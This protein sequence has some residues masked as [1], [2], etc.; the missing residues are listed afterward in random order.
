MIPNPATAPA[1]RR[2]YERRLAG[3]SWASL[4]KML[5]RELPREDGALWRPSTVGDLV[6][7]PL[8]IGRLERT[9]GGERMVKD[10]A[11][12]PLVSR[13]VWEAVVNDR[14]GTRGPVHRAE[15]ATLAGLVRC[16]GCG[17]PCLA[18]GTAR[19]S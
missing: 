11:H 4:A 5:D 18:P 13:A 10:D 19:A 8:N 3:D 15:P 6:T 14:D 12:E 1:I 2:V 16:A 7:T 17:A 9:I